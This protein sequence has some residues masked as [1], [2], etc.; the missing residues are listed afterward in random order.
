MCVF[1]IVKVCAALQSK[2]LCCPQFFLSSNYPM[3]LFPSLHKVDVLANPLLVRQSSPCVS[4]PVSLALHSPLNPLAILCR[5]LDVNVCLCL[6]SVGLIP[7]QLSLT[8]LFCLPSP[9][10]MHFSHCALRELCSSHCIHATYAAGMWRMN[11]Q[12][13]SRTNLQTHVGIRTGFMRMNVSMSVCSVCHSLCLSGRLCLS[14]NQ[15]IC[16]L[17]F[18]LKAIV[19]FCCRR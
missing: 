2:K 3:S 1:F 19:G 11:M 6:I 12:H 16:L 13:M 18:I 14:T 4:H 17:P 7:Q 5:L 10:S 9:K 8:R 15:P